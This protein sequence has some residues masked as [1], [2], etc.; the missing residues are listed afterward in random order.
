MTQRG[1][2]RRVLAALA[3]TVAAVA[4]CG[5]A[6]GR[7]PDPDSSGP[8]VSS[9]SSTALPR[10]A[11]VVVVIFENHAASQV[12]DTSSAPYLTGLAHRG[13]YFVHA[14]GV[15]H[16]SEPNYVALFSG[17]T[18][19]LTS[20]ACPVNFGRKPNLAT[21]LAAAGRTFTGYAEGLPRAGYTG[22]S[23]GDYARKH[24]PWVDFAGLPAG[25]SRPYQAFPRRFSRLPTVAFVV[26]N[27]CHDMHDCSVSTGDQWARKH[28]S[29]YVRWALT[30][31]SLLVVTFDEDDGTR[32]NHIA[33]LVVG[34]M[35]RRGRVTQ[36]IDHDNVLR[37]IEDM[38]QLRPLGLARTA[39]PL[40]CWR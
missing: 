3:V 20:D 10:P 39:A 23:S 9:S 25:T 37:T 6:G 38:Y 29:R 1:A 22:C 30:H 34:P 14:H 12:I 27:L 16:P 11:H 7:T 36:L 5:A 19:R 17:S 31:N 35:V 28:L 2:H 33:T 32:A 40:R 13:A 21:Q 4:G 8:V 15:A 26:P 24:A 18:H